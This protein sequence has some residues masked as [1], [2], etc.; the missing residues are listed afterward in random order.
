MEPLTD[1]FGRRIEYLRVSVTDRCNMRCRYCMPAEGVSFRPRE[2]VLRYEEILRVVRKMA[3]LGV[4]RFRL[5]G[6]EPLVRRD[7]VSLV[8]G[9]AR[10]PGLEDL[11][12]TTN[13][14][15]LADL[16]ADLKA[17]GLRR[18]NVSLDS[19]RPEVFARITR[20]GEWK[21]V[22]RGIW[23]ALEMGLSPVKL[24]VVLLKGFNASEIPD[25]ARLTL[26]HP[27]HVR[28]I[29]LMPRGGGGKDHAGEFLPVGE[30]RA[31]CEQAG[32]LEPAP[33][34]AGVGPASSFRF[35]GAKGTVGFIG[36]LTCNFCRQCNRMRLGAD[37]TL[38]PCL[39][40][41][42]GVGLREVLRAGGPDEELESR[43]REAVR[44]KP[45]GHTMKIG[46][47]KMEWEPMC[48][49]GG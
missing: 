11:A 49:A 23:T 14:V 37:G 9:I 21:R 4:R 48:A 19:L 16:A 5:T 39:D 41:S 40:N 7:L 13:G 43:I 34:A 44:C 20:L 17:A 27:L 15:L 10:V 25:F 2:E 24:N 28:F 33:D 47:G 1:R 3:E 36:A 30:A 6:G 8:G 35:P 38:R 42:V 45:E 32:P 26:R 18:V 22:W 29:E 12:L 31:L 46:S